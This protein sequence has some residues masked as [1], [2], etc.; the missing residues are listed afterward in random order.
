MK[1]LFLAF[2]KAAKACKHL[3][4]TFCQMAETVKYYIEC[5][6][7]ITRSNTAFASFEALVNAPGGYFPSFPTTPLA[8]SKNRVMRMANGREIK[9]TVYYAE[10]EMLAAAYDLFQEARGDKRRAF[11]S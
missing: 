5:L 1:P 3:G 11:R 9:A 4:G 7:G 8:Y 6:D 2:D 10:L